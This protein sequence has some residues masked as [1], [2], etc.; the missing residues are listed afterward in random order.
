MATT[1]ALQALAL[2]RLHDE[3]IKLEQADAWIAQIAGGGI[4]L[5]IND[6][7]IGQRAADILR[8]LLQAECPA[9]ARRPIEEGADGK[10]RRLGYD[11]Q[12]EV[13]TDMIKA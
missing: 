7:K 4:S 8:N 3:K 10:D 11:A 5:K 2:A 13:Y 12:A 1:I 9:A 6:N